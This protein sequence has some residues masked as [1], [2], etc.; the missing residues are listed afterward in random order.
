MI[1]PIIS[2]LVITS[3]ELD[4]KLSSVNYQIS[5]DQ[6]SVYFNQGMI[7]Y[8][9]GGYNEAI[10]LFEKA[11]EIKPG[12]PEATMMIAKCKHA[13]Q[14][15]EKE[16]DEQPKKIL[17]VAE[18]NFAEGNYKEALKYFEKYKSMRPEDNSVD[19]KIKICREKVGG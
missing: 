19:E 12:D 6:Y 8:N 14:S 10:S 15:Q 17:K 18:M 2:F 11:L 5:Q 3:G 13:K 7:S 1:I 4:M 16:I 9:S